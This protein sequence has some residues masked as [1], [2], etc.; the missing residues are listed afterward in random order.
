MELTKGVKKTRFLTFSIYL[1]IKKQK[2]RQQ[3]SNIVIPKSNDF[4]NGNTLQNPSKIERV[5]PI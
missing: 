5:N 1:I 2:K 4:Q 3:I